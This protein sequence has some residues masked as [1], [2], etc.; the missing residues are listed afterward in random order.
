MFYAYSGPGPDEAWSQPELQSLYVQLSDLSEKERLLVDPESEF[1]SQVKL[2]LEQCS[3]N[4][5]PELAK[6]A[7]P[8]A[9]VLLKLSIK[10]FKEG[11]LRVELIASEHFTDY[12][13]SLRALSTVQ[14]GTVRILL[15]CET[16]RVSKNQN[17]LQGFYWEYVA[18]YLLLSITNFQQ[19]GR[20]S[21][22]SCSR[23]VSWIQYTRCSSCKDLMAE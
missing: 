22:S 16:K 3:H 5:L 2:I 10:L 19:R 4:N 11:Q 8:E 12:D 13:N 9:D 15:A 21:G 18:C 1:G 14:R 6:R 23:K 20:T 7:F 17:P